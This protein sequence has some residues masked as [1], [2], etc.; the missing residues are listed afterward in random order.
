MGDADR[1]L[2][3]TR[4]GPLWTIRAS[5]AATRIRSALPLPHAT[6]G[7]AFADVF[8][9]ERFAAMLPL[10]EFL[11]AISEEAPVHKPPLRATFIVDDPNLHWPRYGFVDY[12]QI[13][14]H[15]E[16]E[17]YHVAFA[18]IPL[19]TWFAHPAAVRVFRSHADTISL[20]VHGNNHARD[21]LT[22]LGSPAARFLALRQAVARIERLEQRTGLRVSRIMVPPHGACSSAV[23]RALPACGFDAACVSTGSLRYHNASEA[24]TMVAGFR[25]SEL[26]EGCPVLP[27]WAVTSS[28]A[29][30][31]LLVA[32]YLGQAMVLRG[33]HQ[34]FRGGPD[35]FDEL[36]RFIN[37][38]GDV[39]WTNAEGLAQAGFLWRMRGLRCHV[40]PLGLDIR[41]RPPAGTRELCIDDFD[42][43]HPQVWIVAWQDG[44]NQ[45]L[46]PGEALQL[47]MDGAAPIA[48]RR[49]RVAS[50]P[51]V[52]R[53]GLWRTRPALVL[54]RAVTEA[55]DRVIAI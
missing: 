45:R 22:R 48:L 15:A 11:R 55:R 36:A 47:P 16:R 46:R 18:T 51:D 26:V 9:G 35:L 2:A 20:L 1:V 34:D 27:R 54:R 29:R 50:P 7:T 49:E 37:G 19:D 28:T 32:A 10:I 13:A 4:E 6:A 12:A 25:P 30:S 38:M 40:S 21:E 24:W 14:A 33:H 42:A 41:F 52:P 31:D 5:P 23:L 44:R 3:S 53:R 17:N 39:R 8:A 43:A